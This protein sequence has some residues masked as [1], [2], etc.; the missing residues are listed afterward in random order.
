MY[1]PDT[2]H[3]L[4][5]EHDRIPGRLPGLTAD[6][7]ATKGK[8]V[9]EW[10]DLHFFRPIG[11][12]I[13]QHLAHTRVT[14]DQ[15]TL[16]SLIIGLGA[17]HLFVYANPWLNGLGFVLFI[18]SDL[19]DSADGQLARLRGTST[20]FGRALDGISDGLRFVNLGGHLLVRLVLTGGW[21]WP[22][23]T[24]LVAVAAVSQSA[25]NA[26]IDFIR[27]AFLA[28]AVGRGS[29]LGIDESNEPRGASRRRR[30][31]IWIYRTYS[32]RQKRMFPRTAA[33]LRVVADHGLGPS[34]A[35]VYRAR[36]APVV[37]HC[38]WLGQN[39]RFVILGVTAVAGWPAG[40]LWCTVGP[41]NVV[42]VWLLRAQER[43][44]RRALQAAE[45][46]GAGSPP[47]GSAMMPPVVAWRVAGRSRSRVR[48]SSVAELSASIAHEIN[49]PL[50]S[51]VA[52]AHA[53]QAWLSHEPPN[54]A[55]A[56][57]TLQRIIREGHFA[58]EVVQ[59]IRGLFQKAAP[60]KA[61]VSINQAVAEVLHMLSDEIRDNKIVA[62]TELAP[63]L[64]VIDADPVQIQQVLI[65]LVHNAIESMAGRTDQPKVLVLRSQRR[66]EE[67]F[68]Q[69]CDHGV[70]IKD[71]TLVFEPFFTTKE[72]GMGMGLAIARSIVEAHG[73][74][75][76]AGANED[77]GTTFSLTLP[78]TS[79]VPAWGPPR[80]RRAPN[81]DRFAAVG[82]GAG[83]MRARSRPRSSPEPVRR[84]RR[85]R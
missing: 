16:V 29:E 20:Q 34:A 52:N 37:Q 67:L 10:A 44:A 39:F 6:R 15:V 43:G 79:S 12:R 25:Q 36:I 30:L 55:R 33:L 24:A 23:A 85:P 18:V 66:G 71:P 48:G 76:Q 68:I 41:M 50:A 84:R 31:A 28:V 35:A 4:I 69:V 80:V 59:R 38:A 78:L 17:G 64:P 2:G 7:L 5:I 46:A 60:V 63:D 13:A 82:G 62:E 32:R 54:L 8:D 56:Q 14:A 9:E 42:L 61:P 65:N 22:A 72:S 58:A 11:A 27:Q 19:F 1:A 40:L 26:A 75:I 53:C 3:M 70:G 49:Q 47:T 57:V 81:G 45:L 74:H 73:G 77:R 21:S 83:V 51:L